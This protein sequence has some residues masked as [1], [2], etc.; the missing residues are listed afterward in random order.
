MKRITIGGSIAAGIFLSLGL[1]AP[2]LAAELPATGTA[3]HS[4]RSEKSAAAMTPAKKCMSDLRAFDGQMSKDGYRLVGAGYGGYGYPMGDRPTGDH[5][6]A[7]TARP[8]PA[9]SAADYQNAR[10][11]YEIR[12]LLASADIRARHGQQQSCEHL[13]TATR[14]IY[15]H[16]VADM[17]AGR[18]PAADM[19]SWR[20]HQI[21][22]AQPVTSKNI[23]FRSDQLIGTDVRD[24]KNEALGSVD[25]LVI[26]PQ[27]GKIAYLVIARGGVFGIDE[28][29][30]PVPWQDFK[31][32][33]NVDLLV[34]D[35][36]KGAM[37]A[38]P[39]VKSDRF[40]SPS[41]FDRLS[42]K[43]DTYWNT[44]LTSK[45]DAGSNG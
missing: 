5:A 15:R 29:Y 38:A 27:T 34:L 41:H 10:P 12:T 11:G 40:A 26:S 44:H 2:L 39:Q 45:G 9:A 35:T 18:V 28:K 21:A 6:A 4:A 8:A 36:S 33:P 43:V 7:A 23:S 17:H 32:T 25:D 19:Q 22:A 3:H 16:D 24:A 14:A 31:V 30:V 37:D 1:T 20:L 42:H 13:L